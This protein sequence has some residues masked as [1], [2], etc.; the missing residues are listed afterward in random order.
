MTIEMIK[1]VPYLS[2]EQIERNANALLTEFAHVRGL[3]IAPPIPI[4]DIVEKHLKLH[5]EFDDMHARIGLPRDLDG[6]ATILGEMDFEERL[7]RIDESLDPEEHPRKEARYRFTVAHEI[8]H[9]RLHRNL[10]AKDPTRVPMVVRRTG[11]IHS[12]IEWQAHFFGSCV[13][14]PRNLVRD[15]WCGRFGNTNPRILRGKNYSFLPGMTNEFAAALRSFNQKQEEPALN[16]FAWFFA[17]KFQVSKEAMRIRLEE[18]GLLHRE[19][20]RQRFG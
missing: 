18:M 3:V 13:L 12:R 19:F 5:F 7:I 2:V 15:A 17:Q 9:W 11:Q 14:M 20:P 4:E 16:E 10:C 1:S 8:G 6:E